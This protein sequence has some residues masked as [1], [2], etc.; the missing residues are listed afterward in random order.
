MLATFKKML[1]SFFLFIFSISI[2]FAQGSD[3][4]PPGGAE[5]PL[6]GGVFGLLA[7]GAIYGTKKIY[8][9]RKQRQK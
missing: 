8:D 9:S 5:I 1:C 7:A 2:L 3:P 6:D 4:V